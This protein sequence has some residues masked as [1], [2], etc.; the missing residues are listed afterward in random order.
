[1][2][3]W[4]CVCRVPTDTASFHKK[5]YLKIPQLEWV[6]ERSVCR[7]GLEHIVGACVSARTRRVCVPC[8]RVSVRM[9]CVCARVHVR[10]HVRR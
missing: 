1:M 8:A 4:V 6:G 5:A 2:C 10:V 3:C 9:G 7:A